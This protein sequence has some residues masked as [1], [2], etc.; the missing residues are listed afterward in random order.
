MKVHGGK[1]EMSEYKL[2]PAQ[3]RIVEVLMKRPLEI[4]AKVVGYGWRVPLG[5]EMRTIDALV[6][7]GIVKKKIAGAGF[8]RRL[9][10]EMA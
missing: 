4:P 10:V 1:V 2:T 8:K 7:R 6:R 3:E 5:V 9:I